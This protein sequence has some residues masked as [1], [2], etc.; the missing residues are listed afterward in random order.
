M[1][2]TLILLVLFTSFVSFSTW[3]IV[4]FQLKKDKS[5]LYKNVSLVKSSYDAYTAFKG[6][7]S[8]D[9]FNEF[10]KPLSDKVDK[11][12]NLICEVTYPQFIKQV[13]KFIEYSLNKHFDYLKELDSNQ[14]LDKQG[15]N[16]QNIKYVLVKALDLVEQQ[17]MYIIHVYS[18]S[19]QELIESG[20]NKGQ[21]KEAISSEQKYA[22]SVKRLSKRLNHEFQ[23]ENSY[24]PRPTTRN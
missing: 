7:E 18:D 16:L 24:S 3:T 20:K 11:Q 15:E 4:D 22:S 19:T 6:N 14:Y 21:L 1:S 23:E 17:R 12:G 5:W 8:I 2:I 10:N 9:F 13:E